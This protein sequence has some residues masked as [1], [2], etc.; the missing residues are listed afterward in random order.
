M[1]VFHFLFRS[2]LSIAASI[3]VLILCGAMV[4]QATA[5][6]RHF[7][8]SPQYVAASPSEFESASADADWQQEMTLL[9][10]ATSTQ[11]EYG[12]D[13]D[14]IAMI[15]PVV[16][17][18]LIGEY[19]GLIDSGTYTQAMGESAA[20]DIAKNVRAIVP[21]K[22]YTSLDIKTDT[23][24]SYERM[25]TYRSDLR[26]ALAPLLKNTESELEIYA[27]YIE[28]SDP[29]HLAT[30]IAVAKNY[31]AAAKAVAAVTIP[32]DAMN[33]HLDILNAIEYFAST[34]EAMARSEND[35]FASVALLRTYNTAEQKMFLTF[36]AL[37][38]YYGQK[39]P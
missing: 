35:A 33:Y 7:S 5:L 13:S 16:V 6:V 17:A 37:G 19:A 4:W 9:G 18:Q 24:I 21:Y 36:D 22:T 29:S 20:M 31:R 12:T 23:D 1:R 15:G 14:P 34:L 39:T 38:N 28:T 27:K 2:N 32:R 11:V 25:L 8:V 3:S 30:L 10:L 26:E